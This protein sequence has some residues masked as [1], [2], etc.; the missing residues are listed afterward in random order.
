MARPRIKQRKQPSQSYGQRE[1]LLRLPQSYD[2]EDSGQ[3]RIANALSKL[4]AYERTP[5]LFDEQEIADRDNEL[6][7]LQK[8]KEADIH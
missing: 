6:R 8:L 2:V 1:S 7:A 4:I 3:G 5:S